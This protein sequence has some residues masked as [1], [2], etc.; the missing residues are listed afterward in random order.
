MRILDIG[1]KTE[2]DYP[3]AKA[4][5][6]GNDYG[7]RGLIERDRPYLDDPPAHRPGEETRSRWGSRPAKEFGRDFQ[8]EAE[9][10]QGFARRVWTGI[11]KF[12]LV[13]A[14]DARLARVRG[15]L[16]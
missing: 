12:T 10:A 15:R 14:G 6:W 3:E 13:G 5:S 7:P 16:G 11:K 9:P 4:T 2:M 8:V 1:G